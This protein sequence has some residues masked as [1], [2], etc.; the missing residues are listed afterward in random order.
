MEDLTSGSPVGLFVLIVN[1]AMEE[2]GINYTKT[3]LSVEVGL[4]SVKPFPPPPH[5][6]TLLF[7]LCRIAFL[8]W[9]ED[10]QR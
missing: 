1:A 6:H 10:I 2:V 8:I 4:P 9:G 7:D 5:T 3:M